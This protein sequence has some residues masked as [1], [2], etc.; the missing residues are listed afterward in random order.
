[1]RI[2]LEYGGIVGIRK[3]VFEMRIFGKI[4]KRQ[5]KTARDSLHTSKSMRMQNET[6]IRFINHGRYRE[7]MACLDRALRINSS[8]PELWINKG[9]ALFSLNKFTEA[10]SSY[11]KAIEINPRHPD[12]WNGKGMVLSR[13]N[14][15]E[16]AI[17][18]YDR[19]LKINPRF[20]FAWHNMAF[21]LASLK[22]Y[23]EALHCCETALQ[24]NPGYFEAWGTKGGILASLNSFEEALKC[25][26]MALKI[27]SS[28]PKEWNDKANVLSLLN[29]LNEA[30]Y[31]HDRAI[32]INPDLAL[33][34]SSKGNTLMRLKRFEDAI[35]CCDKAL[36]IDKGLAEAWNNKGGALAIL[37]KYEDALLCCEKA[38]EI[39]P[40]N[41]I[42]L[43]GKK[44]CLGKIREHGGDLYT[45][46]HYHDHCQVEVQ[47]IA[48]K[49]YYDRLRVYLPGRS[50]CL[51]GA[52]LMPGHG[53]QMV[54]RQGHAWFINPE[55]KQ[56]V[57][58]F[59]PANEVAANFHAKYFWKRIAEID[60]NLA[61][62]TVDTSLNT[63]QKK[64]RRDSL[65]IDA[66]SC[67]ERANKEA[68]KGRYNE[69]ITNYDKTIS[70]N[71]QFVL[72]RIN[73]SAILSILDREAEAKQSF[74]K[75]MTI[76]CQI[77]KGL[78]HRASF[79][80]SLGFNEN[81]YLSGTATTEES[82]LKIFGKS[83]LR[84][85]GPIK[86]LKE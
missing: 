21:I 34:W 58:V 17:Q 73:R 31:C 79:L 15:P 65:G 86:R 59:E 56:L 47:H 37:G 51:C 40:E 52:K 19:A 54:C 27:N 13:L 8:I 16:G 81:W 61:K 18:C 6:A 62:K 35:K 29:R 63:L 69:A 60:I 48:A 82:G 25:Y 75:A 3:E 77:H 78:Q 11:D 70:L 36:S 41:P 14:N 38:I 9:N 7:A 22:R 5:N 68:K 32:G 45:V 67:F 84:S 76:D 1:M 74:N 71:P 43:E 46:D 64:Y 50:P 53:K 42:F 44:Y 39:N 4:F 83:E 10:M 72:A 2:I 85:F 33:A 80:R 24:I 66:T 23:K 57:K 26:N 12:A 49:E 28:K 30:L 20:P 55:E